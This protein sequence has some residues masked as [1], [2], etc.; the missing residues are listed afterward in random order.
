MIPITRAAEILQLST[1]RL[2]QL[3]AKGRMPGARKIGRDWLLP[4]VPT[5]TPG[6]M[7]RPRKAK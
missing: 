1:A 5:I 7:G 3:C 4:R 2:R 6:V